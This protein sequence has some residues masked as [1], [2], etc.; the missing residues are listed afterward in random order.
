MGFKGKVAI[1]TGGASGIGRAVGEKLARQGATVILADINGEHAA[2]TAR[3]INAK[4]GKQRGGK[5]AGAAL[6]VTDAVA[7]E[8]LIK[9]AAK[10][11]GRCDYLFNNAGVSIAAEVRD[12]NLDDWNHII[13]VNIRGVIHGVHAA[14]PVMIKQGSGHIVNTASIAGLAPFPIST[15]YTATKHAVAGLSIALRAEAAGLGVKVSV[16]CPGFIDTPM[17]ESIKSININKDAGEKAMPFNYYPVD[18]CADDILKGV[19]QNK[20]IITITSHAELLWMLYRLSPELYVWASGFAVNKSRT[21]RE[22]P[23]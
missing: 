9:N 2:E 4:G 13:D 19:A 15:A 10:E 7:F 11:H 6:D 8:A 1:I 21:M 3:G 14:Y 16:V 20:A 17:R 12:M 22:E 23:D 18:K 5:A